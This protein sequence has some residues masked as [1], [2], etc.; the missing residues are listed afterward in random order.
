MTSRSNAP[1]RSGP[2]G[3]EV[4]DPPQPSQNHHSIDQTR[5]EQPPFVSRP[6]SLAPNRTTAAGTTSGPQSLT[7]SRS[8]SAAASPWSSRDSSPAGRLPRQQA[9]STA[10]RGM[11]SRKNS[12]D[13]SPSRPTQPL[14]S[15]APSAAAIKRALSAATAPQLQPG[16]AAEPLS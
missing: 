4:L 11:R 2:Q 15:T 9:G 12:H 6:Y 8:P 10:A 5:V 14:T 1:S 7:A 16:P 3:S 13:A